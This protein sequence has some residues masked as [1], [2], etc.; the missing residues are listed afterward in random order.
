MAKRSSD[1]TK[2]TILIALG[3]LLVFVIIWQF[4]INTGPP[5][6]QGRPGAAA[7][8]PSPSGE[9]QTAPVQNPERAAQSASEQAA[10]AQQ[11]VS[12]TTPLDLS[13][14]AQQAGSAQVSGRGNIFNYYVPPPPPPAPTP[15]PPPIALQTVQPSNAVAGTPR[16]FT[17][18]IRGQGFPPDAQIIL[19][20][21]PRQTRRVDDNTLSTE[22]QP[23]DYT[24]QRSINIE[25]R[26]QSDPAKMFSNALQFM[27]QAAPEPPFKY[28][29]RLGEQGLFEMSGDRRIERLTRGS[30]IQGVW[31]IDSITD[32]NVE[33]THTQ[34]GIKKVVK[35][36]DKGR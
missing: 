3:A 14:L 16:P 32:A 2:R 33:V 18:T 31:R 28:V 34:Y 30:T 21:G 5:P 6:R 1:K 10:L 9:R 15:T 12:D 17:M 26:S 22:I 7:S 11:Q 35:M 19:D 13:L 20:G 25:V 27:V 29:G 24:T 8:R 36:A 4:F 23:G